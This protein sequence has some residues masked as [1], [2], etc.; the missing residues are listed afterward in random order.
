MGKLSFLRA[1]KVSHDRNLQL[2]IGNSRLTKEWNNVSISWS[3][4]IGRLSNPAKT[5]E[6]ML[7]FDQATKAERD[8]LKDVGGFVGGAFSGKHRKNTELISRDLVTLDLDNAND[9]VV[10]RVATGGCSAVVYP[11]RSSR[12][13][14]LRYR[15]I[16]PTDRPMTPEEYE[17]VARQLAKMLGILEFCDPTTFQSARLM[18]FPSISID[19]TFDLEHFD[20][21]FVSVDGVLASFDW[22]NATQWPTA[23]KEG[24]KH[25]TTISRQQDPRA[26]GG[27][28]GSF[29]RAY[30][31]SEA[32]E[33][34]L[35]GVYLPTDTEDRFSYAQGSSTG[36]AVVYDDTFLYSHHATD[37]CCD[38]LVNA[39]DLCRIHL[40]GSLDGSR[41]FDLPDHKTSS[42]ASMAKLAMQDEEVVKLVG[43]E[44]LAKAKE[45]FSVVEEP[46]PQEAVSPGEDW[47]RKLDWRKDGKGLKNSLS[48][49]VI[50]LEHDATFRGKIVYDEFTDKVIVTN[51]LP[52]GARDSNREWTD[53]DDNNLILAF[54]TLYSI[55]TNGH[56]LRALDI[57]VKRNKINSVEEYLK[58]ITWDGVP[59]VATLL[60]DFLGAE[61]NEYTRQV[62][63]TTLTNAVKRAIVG[64]TKWDYVP[65]LCGK[66]GIG[67]S[68]LLAALGKEWFN[69]SI[70]TFDGKDASELIQGKWINELP[71]LAA[72]G[73]SET[74]RIK[75]FITKQ[76]D[77][78]RAAYARNPIT[79]PRR[80][81]FIGTTNDDEFL[82]DATGNRRFWPVRLGVVEPTSDFSLLCPEY[83]DEVWAEAYQYYKEGKM[84]YGL[85]GEA[86]A[87]A[88]IEQ[89]GHEVVDDWEGV[90]RNY[91][92]TPKPA[93][94]QDL[95]YPTRVSIL[96]GGVDVD[97]V[98]LLDKV[99]I[100][101]IWQEV[102]QGD[103]KK[104]GWLER[105]RISTI[106]RKL[107]WEQSVTIRTKYCGIQKGFTK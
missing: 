78:Y 5:P 51:P 100:A 28:I 97:R 98:L 24:I 85:T 105:R 106:L 39:F 55:T 58:S 16:I 69:D 53:T 22:R 68:R 6:S 72:F 73:K 64:G 57:V 81:V 23:P 27:V 63:L 103:P 33:K 76:T 12:P 62:M 17:P 102:F 86:A 20:E 2:Y 101:E 18:F 21:P 93:N 92:E 7:E 31:I 54:E 96:H 10:K 35:K 44:K 1:A 48:N 75:Q 40:F 36:G 34:F 32:I 30:S 88:L 19:Q 56:I 74:N 37:P 26:K 80:G 91:L 11:T 8:R 65:I 29:C 95:E 38:K 77:H 45:V 25:R 89:A 60:H 42:F 13:E 46:T 79:R 14:N 83:V 107:G 90:V 3:A 71:E 66:Q 99:C 47:T 4:F 52:W 84:H 15:V 43:E 94:W 82:K 41:E 104:L 50:V 59:R 87:T 49:C 70:Q 61:N 9:S 67:K